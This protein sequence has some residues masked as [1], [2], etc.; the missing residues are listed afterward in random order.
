MHLIFL[1]INIFFYF[2]TCKIISSALSRLRLPCSRCVYL[3]CMRLLCMLALCALALPMLALRAPA[4]RA[5]AVRA[6]AVR[7]RAVCGVL[8]QCSSMHSASTKHGPAHPRDV[9]DVDER[10]SHDLGER[11]TSAPH[12]QHEGAQLEHALHGHAQQAWARARTCRRQTARVHRAHSTGTQACAARAHRAKCAHSEGTHGARR[13]RMHAHDACLPCRVPPVCTLGAAAMPP[14]TGAARRSA[15]KRTRPAGTPP[16]P[17]ASVVHAPPPPS[18]PAPAA[19]PHPHHPRWLHRR[20]RR[21]S[22]APPSAHTAGRQACHHGAGRPTHARVRPPAAAAHPQR[23][24]RPH[25]I[26]L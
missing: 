4:V 7:F 3:L 10:M 9:D 13:G 21:G 14:P 5:L 6:R 18:A 11:C 24:Q 19:A 20:R 17:D 8:V 25:A 22:A 15:G 16:P 26:F 1:F 23:P 12:D 2:H